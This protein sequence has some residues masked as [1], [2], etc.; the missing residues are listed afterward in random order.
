MVIGMNTN[1]VNYNDELSLICSNIIADF[2]F[3]VNTILQV[4]D[5]AVINA[6]NLKKCNAW[7][8]DSSSAEFLFEPNDE[9]AQFIKTQGVE[10]SN[11]NNNSTPIDIYGTIFY[12]L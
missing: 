12:L 2:D 4:K 10:L 6:V 7:K 8:I 3:N 1:F 5:C 11:L 9:L